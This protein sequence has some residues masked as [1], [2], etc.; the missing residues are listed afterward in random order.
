MQVR[1][2]IREGQRRVRASGTFVVVKMRRTDV[3]RYL[4]DERAGSYGTDTADT[5]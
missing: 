2:G 3:T 1:E 5:T 4:L